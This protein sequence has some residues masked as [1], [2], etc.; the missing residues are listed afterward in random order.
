[1]SISIFVVSKF[2]CLDSGRIS[3]TIHDLLLIYSRSHLAEVSVAMQSLEMLR[4]TS[5]GNKVRR[6]LTLEMKCDETIPSKVSQLVDVNVR[7][8]GSSQSSSAL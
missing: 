5:Q 2:V 6:D 8:S 1:M 4:I 3:N 7:M